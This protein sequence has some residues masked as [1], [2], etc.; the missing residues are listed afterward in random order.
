MVA[1]EKVGM[2]CWMLLIF[3]LLE[4]DLDDVFDTTPLD[5]LLSRSF[6]I[7]LP[8]TTAFPIASRKV[9]AFQ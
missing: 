4:N 9:T 3:F 2:A 5:V 1:L 8:C 6:V 7:C